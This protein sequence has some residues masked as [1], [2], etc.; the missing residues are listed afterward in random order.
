MQSEDYRQQLANSIKGLFEVREFVFENT[1]NLAMEGDLKNWNDSIENG[2]TFLFDKNL[3]LSCGDTNVQ[4][5]TELI[6]KIETTFDSLEN[7]N[8]F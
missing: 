4:L 3:L 2:E 8:N 7:I 1:L 5:L 6:S